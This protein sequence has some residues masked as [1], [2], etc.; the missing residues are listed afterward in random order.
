MSKKIVA[1]IV[2]LLIGICYFLIRWQ[3]AQNDLVVA[4]AELSGAQ[5]ALE[6]SAGEI[7]GTQDEVATLKAEL[8]D[9]K[10]YLSDV[11]AELESTRDSMSDV[12]AELED[13]RARLSAVEADALHLHNPTFEEARDFLEE[14]RTDAN[15][16]LED[17]YVCSHFAADVNNNA[18][19]QGI[20]C[21]LVDV[22]FPRSGHAIIA[23]DTTDKG[24]VYF[25]P[26]TDD[27]V[28]PV[29]GKYYWKCIEPEPGYEY[30]KPSFDDTIE[31]IVVIW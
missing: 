31:D 30:E 11:E 29:I 27:R 3:L 22:R 26:I 20:R 4:R 1:L 23:F 9:T 19:R 15:E 16:Y 24:L 10:D 7:F 2:V 18:E 8:K 6:G 13:T 5:A 12:V 14:D 21:A 25:D 28:R 17:E